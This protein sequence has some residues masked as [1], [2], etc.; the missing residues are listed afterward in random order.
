MTLPDP[1]LVYEW[2]KVLGYIGL[3]YL[4]WTNYSNGDINSREDLSKWISI[5]QRFDSAGIP[6]AGNII[7]QDGKIEEVK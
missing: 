2:L 3:M 6:E 1:K 5:A 4:G 7:V